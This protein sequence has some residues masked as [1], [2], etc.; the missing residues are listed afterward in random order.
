VRRCDTSDDA[1]C[2]D[3]NAQIAELQQLIAS[4]KPALE[5]MKAQLSTLAAAPL[6]GLAPAATAETKGGVDVE[7]LTAAAEKAT[8]DFGAE[9]PEAKM[10]WEAVED[11]YDS[12]NAATASAPGLDEAC[13]TDAVE[14]CAAFETAMA[15]LEE[16]IAKSAA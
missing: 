13:L 14:K 3:Y 10:A 2:I 11:M 4:S 8:A 1:A 7:A 12:A 16:S 15:A 5:T 9:S 6:A